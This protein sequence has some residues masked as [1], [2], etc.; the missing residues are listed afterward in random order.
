MSLNFSGKRIIITTFGSFGDLHPYIPIALELKGRGY[1]PV[2]ATLPLYREKLEPLGVGFHPVR[3]DLPHPEQSEEI[4]AK[5]MDAKTGTEFIFKTLIMPH[6]R[7][8][9]EDL[10][11]AANGAS[12]LITHPI[13]FAGPIVAQEL[14]LPWASSVLAPASFFSAYDPPVTPIQPGLIKLLRLHPV[15]PRIFMALVRKST[16][17]WVEPVYRLRNELGLPPAGHPIFEGQHSPALVLA[18]FSR[19][20]ADPQ[21]DWPPQTRITGFP[22]Y[23]RKDESSDGSKMPTDLLRFLE[24]GPPPIVFTLGSSAVWV[25]G[26]FFRE[27]IAAALSLK[28]RA[29]LLIGDVRNLRREPLPE[30]IVAFD[31]APYGELLPRACAIVHQ[32]G[33]GTTA[34]AL[35][36]GKPMLVVPYS[37]DQ[38]DNGARVER[39]GVGR[40]LPRQRY[41]AARAASELGELLSN[42]EYTQKAA[43]IGRRVRS[44]DGARTASD[45]IEELLGK[46][47]KP[48]MRDRREA[49]PLR[50]GAAPD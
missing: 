33:I 29:V 28:R 17:S 9:Y 50:I 49:T 48:S 21:P 26:D 41:T 38:P 30:G 43:E 16:A 47:T 1:H 8:S 31:Y 2:I 14:N 20:L 32:G 15:I 37:H 44:E 39:L 7:D 12:L 34:Q 27:S 5:A 4:I 35:R 42:L 10:R 13:T 23:D 3:P 25:A 40:V 22:F 6:L 46:T 24:S 36:A 11:K 19:V 18:L 45:A